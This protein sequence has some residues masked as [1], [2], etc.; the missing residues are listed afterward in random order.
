MMNVLASLL[1]AAVMIIT[2]FAVLVLV[3]TR[4]HGGARSVGVA[5]AVLLMVAQLSP[6][7]YMIVTSVR[8]ETPD[9]SD[10]YVAIFL[11]NIVRAVL[12]GAGILLLVRCVIMSN[13]P[14][15]A[16]QSPYPMYPGGYQ[17]GPTGYQQGP[18]G[19]QQGPTTYQRGPGSYDQGA[20]SEPNP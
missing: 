2:G 4:S 20:G 1:P 14:G 3:L 18:T 11:Q 16:G 10:L 6:L 19:Y 8:P 12:S 13:R 17:P 9:N 7:V 5:G 15:R